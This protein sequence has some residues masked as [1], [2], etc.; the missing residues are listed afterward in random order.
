[1]H[2]WIARRLIR[3]SEYDGSVIPLPEDNLKRDIYFQPWA[4]I[5]VYLVGMVTGYVL[6]VTKMKIKMS[7][8]RVRNHQCFSS[9]N[10]RATK[11]CSYWGHRRSIC[12]AV[13]VCYCH[14]SLVD[15]KFR[16]LVAGV[17]L[18]IYLCPS[19]SPL[20]AITQHRLGLGS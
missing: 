14:F 3:Q 13:L 17:Q 18:Y 8:V 9:K 2:R 12:G 16:F 11:N 19:V 5:H 7:K 1:M 10:L 20:V 4:R 6:F 15:D